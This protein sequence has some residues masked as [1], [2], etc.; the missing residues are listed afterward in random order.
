MALLSF[1][2][3]DSDGNINVSRLGEHIVGAG[4]FIDIAERT[5]ELVFSGAFT[6][7]GL[8]FGYDDGSLNI[9]QVGS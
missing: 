5:Q 6:A 3:F 9:L 8:K 2:Q 1:G 4:G 7:K